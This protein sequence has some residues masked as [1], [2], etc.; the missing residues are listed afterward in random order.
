MSKIPSQDQKNRAQRQPQAIVEKRK[1][2]VVS[3]KQTQTVN[4]CSPA[5]QW[6]LYETTIRVLEQPFVSPEQLRDFET[7]REMIAAL[8]R[9]HRVRVEDFESWSK[10]WKDLRKSRDPGAVLGY[11]QDWK[12][13]EW[14]RTDWSGKIGEYRHDEESDIGEKEIESLLFKRKDIAISTADGISRSTVTPVYHQLPLANQ[15]MGQVI[16][17]ALGILEYPKG[18][19]RPVMVEVKVD[20]NNCWFAL[21]ECLQQVQMGRAYPPLRKFVEGGAIEKG[22]WGMVLAP[23]SYFAASRKKGIM[24]PCAE[25]LSL[26]KTQTQARIA[27]ACSDRLKDDGVIEIQPEQNWFTTK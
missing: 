3:G 26:L 20:A 18:K 21:I 11:W 2:F 12:P 8:K 25:L 14:Q 23:S 1:V 9:K 24:E 22:V 19:K 15:R 13:K 7:I 4:V 27:F 6:G 10:G 16:S 17:D 5:N